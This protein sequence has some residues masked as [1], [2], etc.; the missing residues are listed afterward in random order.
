[1]LNIKRWLTRRSGAAIPASE[2]TAMG[3]WASTRSMTYEGPSVHRQYVVRGDWDGC[4]WTLERRTGSRVFIQGDEFNGRAAMDLLV[5]PVVIVISRALKNSL[6]NEAYS[7]Y[8][9]SVQTLAE[10]SL[11]EEMRWIALYPECAPLNISKDFHDRFSVLAADSRD[12]AKW[13]TDDLVERVL[14][15]SAVRLNSPFIL[16]LLRGKVY[17]QL[18]LDTTTDELTALEQSVNLLQFAS[19]TARL[20]FSKSA[21]S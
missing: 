7:I 16:M 12:A 18:E 14:M 15:C 10:P 8:T 4:P 19:E 5:N 20:N 11:S 21:G 2:L 13:I 1:M 3:L 9:D 17:V 6:E